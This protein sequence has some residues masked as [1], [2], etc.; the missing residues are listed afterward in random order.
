MPIR[1]AANVSTPITTNF[2]STVPASGSP[3][4]ASRNTS[5]TSGLPG[6]NRIPV[7]AGC[8]ISAAFATARATTVEVIMAV[9][10][11]VDPNDGIGPA[12]AVAQCPSSAVSTNAAAEEAIIV[13]A[14]APDPSPVPGRRG[15]KY[16]RGSSAENS[17]QR[18]LCILRWAS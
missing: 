2:T 9:P 16:C 6:R 10:A 13:T 8:R 15:P 14:T 3:T 4:L 17:M 5:R 11:P 18:N 7:I 1:A 12:P